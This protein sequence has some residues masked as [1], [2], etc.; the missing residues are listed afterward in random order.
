MTRM[1]SFQRKEYAPIE[2]VQTE[3]KGFGLRAA[4]DLKKFVSY[5]VVLLNSA[6]IF[7]TGTRSFTSMLAM[8]SVIHHS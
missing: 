1:Y 5:R 8:S 4:Q 6:D 3:M 7:A 2:I